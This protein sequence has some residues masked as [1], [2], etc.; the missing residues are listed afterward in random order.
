MNKIKLIS[1]LMISGSVICFG[2][3]GYVYRTYLNV[4]NTFAYYGLPEKD[5]EKYPEI[6]TTLFNLKFGVVKF[7]VLGV[8]SLLIGL[9]LLLK[10][11]KSYEQE[12][13]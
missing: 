5:Y 10:K 11:F 13:H 9:F 1:V 7:S 3:A 12:N 2:I 8:L 6:M 4:L